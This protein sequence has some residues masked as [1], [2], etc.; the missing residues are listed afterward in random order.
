ME[1]LRFSGAVL[2]L[3]AWKI[4]LQA[5]VKFSLAALMPKPPKVAKHGKTGARALGER[6][7]AAGRI[8]F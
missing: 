7:L 1:V 4:R 6:R 5:R 2:G 8:G 3:E